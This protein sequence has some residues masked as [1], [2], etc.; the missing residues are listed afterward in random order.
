[1]STQL[2]LFATTA[3]HTTPAAH[4]LPFDAAAARRVILTACSKAGQNWTT[5]MR[6]R[7]PTGMP[8]REV[9]KLIDHL[10]STGILE[11]TTVYYGSE[12]PG[13]NGYKGFTTGYRLATAMKEAA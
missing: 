13:S 7:R 3:R 5:R 12:T 8:T 2:D 1:M 4:Y 10:V 11:A 6:L 9:G